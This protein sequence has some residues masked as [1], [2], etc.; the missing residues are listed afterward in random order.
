MHH[1]IL[2][3]KSFILQKQ[4]FFH[5]SSSAWCAGTAGGGQ[6]CRHHQSFS[7]CPLNLR[8]PWG[9]H[10][11]LTSVFHPLG[12]RRW[13]LE[14]P[15]GVPCRRPA[16]SLRLPL[17]MVLPLAPT[18]WRST[19]A[20]SSTLVLCTSGMTFAWCWWETPNALHRWGQLH[21]RWCHLPY[22]WCHL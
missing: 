20:A 11:A 13:T 18:W 10:I 17:I 9:F 22:R 21:Y 1:N 8:W 6:W 12:S 7:W 3:S 2:N 14:W 16:F 5:C 4:V 19:S 15:W